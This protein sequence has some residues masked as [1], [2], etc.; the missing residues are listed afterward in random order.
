MAQTNGDITD[1]EKA[2]RITNDLVR[3]LGNRGL[4]VMNA[5]ALALLRYVKTGRFNA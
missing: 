3:R 4:R 5:A 1:D 2:V